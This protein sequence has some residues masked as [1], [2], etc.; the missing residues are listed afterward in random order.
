[1]YKFGKFVGAFASYAIYAYIGYDAF[2]NIRNGKSILVDVMSVLFF[3]LARFLVNVLERIA[4]S[5]LYTALNT[6]VINP[7][8][9]SGTKSV[10]E[11]FDDL[12]KDL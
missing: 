6:P 4:E 11:V 9:E 1:M 12:T 5:T 7:F 10:D 2:Q 8:G 3:M